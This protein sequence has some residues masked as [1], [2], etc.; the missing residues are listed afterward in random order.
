MSGYESNFL[1]AARNACQSLNRAAHAFT[2]HSNAL[3]RIA[4]AMEDAND[5]AREGTGLERVTRERDV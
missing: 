3:E 2:R 5:I 4:K 1:A